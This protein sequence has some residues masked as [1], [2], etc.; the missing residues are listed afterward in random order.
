[1]RTCGRF[2]GEELGCDIAIEQ[3]IAV[4][5]EHGGIPDRIL[6]RQSDKPAE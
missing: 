4:L 3:A 6:G 2:A 5:A 1:L